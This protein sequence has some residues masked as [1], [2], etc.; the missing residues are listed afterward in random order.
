MKSDYPRFVAAAVTALALFLVWR[1][2]LPFRLAYPYIPPVLVLA[3]LTGLGVLGANQ[4]ADFRFLSPSFRRVGFL[5]LAWIAFRIVAPHE[6]IAFDGPDTSWTETYCLG[7]PVA[8]VHSPF[9][10]AAY[11]ALFRFA[12]EKD[13][14]LF[15]S[16]S[17]R[18]EVQGETRPD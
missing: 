11:L 12:R 15:N 6:A 9:V 14:T 8:V 16:K 2:S 10:L 1:Y 4:V 3:T 7:L 5:L 17:R 13:P 18:V